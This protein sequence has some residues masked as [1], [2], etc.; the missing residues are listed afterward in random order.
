MVNAVFN[1]AVS[2]V[3][4]DRLLLV[5]IGISLIVPAMYLL[6]HNQWRLLVMLVLVGSLILLWRLSRTLAI[7]MT[8]FYLFLLGDVRRIV[9]MFAGQ[10]GLDPLLLVGALF[11]LYVGLPLFRGLRLQDRLSKTMLTL[12][13][14]MILEMV[15]PKQGSVLVGL[16]AG[17]FYIV[18]VLWFWIG[19]RFGTEHLCFLLLF[20][21]V[22]PL[23]VVA[24]L[25][26]LYQ[27]F[28]G[29]LPWES[30][31][32]ENAI[33]AG[34]NALYLTG[35][36]VRSFGFSVN[37]VE[38]VSLLVVT[39]I[40]LCS[41]AI[42]GRRAYILPVPL[43]ASAI[44]FA[45]TRGA[46]LRVL[47]GVAVVWAVR[48][49]SRN[50]ASFVPRLLFAVTL[51]VSALAYSS[52]QASSDEAPY[53][54]PR[55][56]STSQAA[57]QHVVQGFAHPLDAKSST[58]GAH[59]GMFSYGIMTGLTNPVGSGLGSVTLGADKFGGSGGST[60]IDISDAFYT[61]GIVGGLCFVYMI[62][63]AF[64]YAFEYLTSG[65]KVI[66]YSVIGVLAAMIGAW[67]GQGQYGLAPFVCFCLGFLTKKHLES[68]AEHPPALPEIKDNIGKRRFRRASKP[69]RV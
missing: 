15:N 17:L 20:R 5:G 42:A 64:R 19:R 49:Y 3:G 39:T 68:K 14:I 10:T 45:A 48:G 46:I 58:A 27:T 33:A 21:V 2:I 4:F 63:L 55:N 43:V 16:S 53:V 65:D 60:E 69:A 23:G 38:Y 28:I 57:T 9:S 66:G 51:G 59:A 29:F 13:G 1:R 40:L 22:V 41:A 11:T 56:A 36:H 7:C 30:V 52:S 24:A 34:Y 25:L 61:M 47:F 54:D 37:G 35:R 26:G 32:I 12:L 44:F 31:W 18:P 67:I 8:F 62:Y 6:E 50:R